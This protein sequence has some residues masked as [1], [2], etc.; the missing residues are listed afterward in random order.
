MFVHFWSTPFSSI[1]NLFR[2][3][4][5]MNH[6]PNQTRIWVTWGTT[7]LQNILSTAQRQDFENDLWSYIWGNPI[8]TSKKTLCSATRNSTNLINDGPAPPLFSNEHPFCVWVMKN[9]FL[10]PSNSTS[11]FQPFW[12]YSLEYLFLPSLI[13]MPTEFKGSTLSS[14][15]Q[16]YWPRNINWN[17]LKYHFSFQC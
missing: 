1:M 2:F 14:A 7:D 16:K 11:S 17:T 8:F 6:L 13:I 4:L 10:Y 3:I 9:V 15:W 5:V 12:E